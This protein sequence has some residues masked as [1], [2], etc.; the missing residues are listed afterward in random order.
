MTR[1][2]KHI[3]AGANLHALERLAAWLGVSP[4]PGRGDERQRRQE[5]VMAIARAEKRIAKVQR[6]G[7][8]QAATS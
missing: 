1:F 8:G 5:L 2:P 7:G 6:A 4:A 3:L